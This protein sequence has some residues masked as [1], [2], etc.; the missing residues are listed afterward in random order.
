MPDQ[1]AI[2]TSQ[3][4]N[5][6][7]EAVQRLSKT[8]S[9]VTQRDLLADLCG[10]GFDVKKHHVLRDLRALIGIHPELECHTDDD[11]SG[12]PRKG[13]EYG[14]RWV[15]RDAPPETG[16][17]IPE[18]LS[19]VL[20]SRHL[21]QALPAPL[22]G[23]LGKLFERAESTLNLQQKNGV[24]N[25]SEM[26]EVVVPAQPMLPPKINPEVIQ[27]VHQALIA[28]EQF[29]GVYRN[30]NGE[31]GERVLHPLGLMVREPSLY[32]VAVCDGYEDPRIFALHRFSSAKR[33]HLPATRPADFSLAEY[34][35]RQG[36]FGSG[37]WVLLKARV[38]KN[39][40]NIL[41]ETPLG[42]DQKLSEPDE[43][44]WR[45]LEVRVRDNWQLTWWLMGHTLSII[46]EAPKS[47]REKIINCLNSSICSYL[48][49]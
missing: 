4:R 41:E 12:R 34:L 27:V 15:A 31:E 37:E 20:V 19:L 21:K 47:T 45:E 29:R 36:N 18:A 48:E 16:L 10:Q 43:D 24:A 6:I 30:I 44:G 39:L 49:L 40:G 7:L 33:E 13:V 32:L 3:R 38:A 46:V 35:E 22:S 25:W 1:A 11:P 28:G 5:L 2:A 17:S 9:W 14:Y 23:A 8:R 42:Q 26:V